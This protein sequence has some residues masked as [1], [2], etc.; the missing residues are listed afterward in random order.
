MAQFFRT[1]FTVGAKASFVML[2]TFYV[3]WFSSEKAITRCSLQHNRNK[4]TSTAPSQDQ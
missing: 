3:F 4:S 2:P 1:K